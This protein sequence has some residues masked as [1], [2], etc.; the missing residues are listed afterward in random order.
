MRHITRCLNPKII[1]ICQRAIKLEELSAKLVNYLPTICVNDAMW[2]ASPTAALC[3]S[4]K[5]PFGHHNYAIACL[6]YAMHCA[7]KQAFINWFPSK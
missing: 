1:D 7:Q 5:T 2:A 4:H 3:S 6:S